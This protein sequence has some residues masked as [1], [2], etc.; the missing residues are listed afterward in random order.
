MNVDELRAQ[1]PTTRQMTYLNTGWDGPSPVSVV[2]AIRARLDYENHVGPTST[3]ALETGKEVRE[4]AKEAIAGLVNATPQEILLTENTTEGINIVLNG[5][6]WQ[7]GDEVITCDL[8]HP[9]IL[10]PTYHLQDRK[11]VWVKVLQFAPDADHSAIISA[12]EDALTE[13]TRMV[14]LSHIEYSCGL[15]MPIE[16]IS[17][18]TRPRGIWLMVDGAQGPGHIPLDLSE[19]SCDFYAMPG[20]KWLLGPDGTGALFIREPMIQ[21]VQPDR[22][23]FYSVKKYDHA[24]SYEP[25]TEDI[26]KFVVSTTSTPLRVGFLQAVRFISDVGIDEIVSRSAALATSLRT[27]LSEVNGVKVLSPTDGPGRTSLVSF[28]IG[29][30]DHGAAAKQLWENDRIL[31]RWVRYPD[32]IRASLAFFNTEIE[33]AQL[34]DAVRRLA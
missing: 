13:R 17:R 4:Q 6:P 9:S 29:D 24:G 33:V 32:S 18:L 7:E 15:R 12:V 34:V 21:A 28:T 5:L 16:E 23:G 8:E 2:E 19:L 3:E 1:I 31:A 30:A 10:L 11:G 22:V 25:E 20:Q 27:E 26:D 14:F